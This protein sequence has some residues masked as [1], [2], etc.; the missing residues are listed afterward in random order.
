MGLNVSIDNW[1]EEFADFRFS[2]EDIDMEEVKQEAVKKTAHDLA[3]MVRL[4]AKEADEF[5]TPGINS[6][7]S[8]G[9]GPSMATKDAWNVEPRGPNEYIVKPHPSVEQRAYVL[10]YGYPGR[11]YPN[12]ADALRFTVDGVPVFAEW[13]EGPEASH[14]WQAAMRAIESGNKMVE[15]GEIA[16]REEI[17]EAF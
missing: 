17:E 15:N 10:N 2:V 4:Q 5:T 3:E 9:K 14:Y 13:V 12:N 1:E 7:Y 6:I 8:R 11:I 16:L